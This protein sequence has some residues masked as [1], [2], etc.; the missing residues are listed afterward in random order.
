MRKIQI[1]CPICQKSKRIPIPWEIFNIDEGS[2]LKHP[3]RSGEI[4]DHSFLI[5]LDYQFSIRD[6]EIPGP[7]TDIKK[8]FEKLEKNSKGFDFA[9]Y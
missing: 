7:N 2:L 5:L 8:Y 4:C 3:I 1:V 6:Y 9:Y